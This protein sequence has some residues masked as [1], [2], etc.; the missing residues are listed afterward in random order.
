MGHTLEPKGGKYVSNVK[1]KVT[2]SAFQ[3][4][5]VTTNDLMPCELF[6]HTFCIFFIETES[7]KTK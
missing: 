3:L 4:N 6:L 5:N 7:G 1:H 2:L